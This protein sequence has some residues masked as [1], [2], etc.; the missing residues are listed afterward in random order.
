MKTGFVD[1]YNNKLFL[2]YL[3]KGSQFSLWEL[4]TSD[5]GTEAWI[6]RGKVGSRMLENLAVS[7]DEI[8]LSASEI[9]DKYPHVTA[10]I[11]NPVERFISAYW[12]YFHNQY[13][14][15][16]Q[17]RHLFF[18]KSSTDEFFKLNSQDDI[19]DHHRNF[20]NFVHRQLESKSLFDAFGVLTVTAEERYH[21]ENYVSS[22]F[23]IT[24]PLRVIHLY[25]MPAEAARTVALFPE[26][27]EIF[28]TVFRQT[29]EYERMLVYLNDEIRAYN[30]LSDHT[31]KPNS[32][33]FDHLIKKIIRQRSEEKRRN[34]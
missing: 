7:P 29:S 14:E 3:T 16:P 19:D 12:Q 24:I 32:N 21:F 22:L 34:A 10:L 17:Y 27:Y 26:K 31:H 13:R 20:K 9:N 8:Q 11:R 30:I 28:K 6:T 5:G 1:F 23:A 25:Y 2:E 33:E 18:Q 15:L 4:P